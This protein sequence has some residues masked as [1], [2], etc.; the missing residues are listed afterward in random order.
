MLE[1]KNITLGYTRLN[2]FIVSDEGAPGVKIENMKSGGVI[3]DKISSNRYN[4]TLINVMYHLMEATVWQEPSCNM[5]RTA[6]LRALDVLSVAIDGQGSVMYRI[7]W[8][9]LGS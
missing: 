9:V 6:I 3:I 1:G 8:L 7:S 5:L 4:T 2:V